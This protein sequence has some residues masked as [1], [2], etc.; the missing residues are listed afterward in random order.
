LQKLVRQGEGQTVEFKRKAS[1]P[2]KIIREI[3]AFA[4]SDGG[5]LLV[6]VGD[7]GMLHGL[8]Y[9]SDDKY[10][11]DK[12][13]KHCIKPKIRYTDFLIP[14]NEHRSV[15][16]YQIAASKRKPHYALPR[17]DSSRGTAFIRINDKSIQASREMIEIMKGQ[18]FT[19]GQR[20]FYGENE[21]LLF[22]HL[23]ESGQ[24]TL[25]TY[26]EISGLPRKA[27]SKTLVRLVLSNV[28]DVVLNEKEDQFKFNTQP[29]D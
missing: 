28:L 8:K 2:E 5:H 11:L 4:N 7:N 25:N 10:V 17:Q 23:K 21:K 29:P 1:F 16:V 9:A 6:G 20:I 12:A 24:I 18:R 3:V 15:L 27:A 26:C 13:I 14:V 22:N 19:A